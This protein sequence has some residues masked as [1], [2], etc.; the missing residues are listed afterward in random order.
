MHYN[1]IVIMR[2]FPVNAVHLHVTSL[3]SYKLYK[4]ISKA[5]IY[6][7]SFFGTDNCMG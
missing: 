1:S 6:I 5:W 7:G 3:G 4:G 2:E